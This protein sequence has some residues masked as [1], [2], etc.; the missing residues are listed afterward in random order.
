MWGDREHPWIRP[1]Q[2][3]SAGPGTYKIPAFGDVPHRFQVKLLDDSPNPCAIHS[4]RAV[5]EPPFFLGASA[6]FA[7]RRAAAAAR[8]AHDSNRNSNTSSS[9]S[10]GG[11]NNWFAL[12]SPASSE[13]LRMACVDDITTG[14]RVPRDYRAPVSV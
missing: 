10:E 5:G 2:L 4:S 14:M 1:G 8:S 12:D 9:G 3:F 11:T 7:A 13:R 6:F